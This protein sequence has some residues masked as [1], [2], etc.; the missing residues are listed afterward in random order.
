MTLLLAIPSDRQIEPLLSGYR[1]AVAARR[2]SGLIF[3]AL[4]LVAV[5]LSWVG[6]EVRPDVFWDKLGNFSSYFDRLT[7]LDTGARV[8]TDPVYWFWGLRRWSLQL[9]QTLLIAYVGTTTGLT[10]GV[11]GGLLASRNLV[12][13]RWLRL[14]S[15]RV[16]EFCRTVPDIVF[17]LIFVAAFGIGALARRVG[18][19]AAHHGARSANCSPR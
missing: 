4:L 15:I 7:Q 18:D 13:A 12:R 6:A 8:W 19:R 3:L 1:Q 16:L 10:L 14:V 17:A 9:L 5:A 2:R 11:I